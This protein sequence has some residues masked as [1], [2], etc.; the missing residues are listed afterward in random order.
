MSLVFLVMV[1]Y[2]LGTTLLESVKQ[3]VY[4]GYDII[5]TILNIEYRDFEVLD[6]DRS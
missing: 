3:E 5:V 6:G 2:F 4:C 1:I